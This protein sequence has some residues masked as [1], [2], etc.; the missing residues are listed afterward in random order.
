MIDRSMAWRTL[1]ERLAWEEDPLFR[2]QLETVITHMKCE[3][4]DDLD[5]VLRTLAPEAQYN[6][7]TGGD[8][9]LTLD[10]IEAI[11]NGFYLPNAGSNGE[12]NVYSLLVDKGC[13]VTMA[14]VKQALRGSDL[15]EK[16][17]DID[18]PE[19]FYLRRIHG[20]AV[21]WPFIEDGSLLLGENVYYGSIDPFE[22]VAQHKIA[23]NV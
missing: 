5:G 8:A 21:E 9:P 14:S 12:F 19:A 2:T 3:M 10:G 11:K 16:G 23:P 6:I 1:E 18:D 15:R 4:N 17:I 13:I 20:M 22:L 7:F